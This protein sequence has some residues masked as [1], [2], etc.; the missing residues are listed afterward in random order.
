MCKE[1]WNKATQYSLPRCF[2]KGSQEVKFSAV[3]ILACGIKS[4]IIL[5]KALKQQSEPEIRSQN[6]KLSANNFIEN[7]I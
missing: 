5:C 2:G 7:P 3:K 1:N 6:I 4:L